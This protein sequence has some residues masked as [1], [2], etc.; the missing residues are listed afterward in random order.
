MLLTFATLSWQKGSAA[1]VVSLVGELRK[2]RPDIRVA[3]LSHWPELDGGPARELGIDVVGPAFP[4]RASRD[5]RSV[6]MLWRHL[7]CAG[8]GAWRRVGVGR[9]LWPDDSVAQAYAEADLVIDLS[10]DSYR[11]P[12]GGVAFAHHAVFLAALSTGTPFALASQSLGPFLW[13]NGR[14]VRYLLDRA[15]LVYIRERRTAAILADLGVRPDRIEVAP[16][17]AFALPAASAEPIWAGERMDPDRI[18]R[19]W[20]ALSVSALVLGLRHRGKRYLPEMIELCNHLRRR[21]DASI[22]LVP[23]E[24]SPMPLGADDDRSAASVLRSRMG[25]PH[26]LYA[27]QG[28]YGPGV[29]KGLISRCDAVV[30]ARMHA[31]IAGL[32]TGVATLPVAWSHKYVGLM[33]DIGLADYV[34]D[35]SETERSA[36]LSDLFDRLWE[37]REPIRAHLLDF[38]A[39]AQG[40]IS[41]VVGRLATHLVGAPPTEHT[42]EM[43]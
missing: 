36:S 17:V 8:S 10:G 40:R 21:Y 6:E 34:W 42:E 26:W 16:D 31:A 38:C 9:R 1:Q 11:D 41:A 5:R 20:I 33:E 39:R 14:C 15:E 27:I 18:P 28:D 12:P 30:A 22:F 35:Q 23:H 32:S 3:L 19:P 24:I 2:L 7:R 4:L 25:G 13:P 37:R 43:L 29:L